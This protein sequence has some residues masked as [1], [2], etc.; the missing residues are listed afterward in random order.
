MTRLFAL[1]LALLAACA[2]TTETDPQR[3]KLTLSGDTLVLS[4]HAPI[5]DA[6]APLRATEAVS[7]YCE[8][9]LCAA[10]AGVVYLDI[11]PGFGAAP[12]C[13]ELHPA[14]Y[15]TPLQDKPPDQHYCL[16]LASVVGLEAAA[17]LVTVEGER[18]TLRADWGR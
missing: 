11:P 9:P 8:L 16:D 5:L 1:L 2:P 18:V 7:A 12:T 6:R 4:A 3:A 17:A 15:V 10:E 14:W 13:R